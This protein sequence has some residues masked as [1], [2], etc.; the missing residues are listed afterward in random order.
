MTG[1]GREPSR[2]AVSAGSDAAAAGD[3][4]SA[5]DIEFHRETASSYDAE[6][7]ATYGVYHRLLLEPYLDRLAH[8]LVSPQALDLGCGT[9]VVSLALARRGFDVLGVDHSRDML[10]LAERKLADVDVPGTCRFVVGD[11]RAVPAADDTFDCV[12]CQGLLHHLGDLE[13]CL[14]ELARVLRPGGYFY[15]SD[16]CR[17]VTPLQ[18]IL[19]ALWRLR[20]LGRSAPVSEKPESVEA[21]ISA[22]ELRTTLERLGFEFELQFLTHLP[23]LRAVLPDRLYVLAVRLVSWPWRRRRG[24]LVF[25]FGRKPDPAGVGPRDA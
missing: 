1:P 17:D 3:A 24:D 13:P 4:F 18:R 6:V 23:P 19:R 8:Q 9:G 10:E 11:V 16:P 15:I 5:A 20:R 7:T 12:T 25:V 14:R 22:P 21:P 2:P